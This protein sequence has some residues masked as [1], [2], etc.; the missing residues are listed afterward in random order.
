MNNGK[1]IIDIIESIDASLSGNNYFAAISSSL[2]L[3]EICASLEFENDFSKKRFLKWT[4]K[5]LIPLLNDKYKAYKYLNKD[6]LYYLRCSLFHQGSTDPSTQNKYYEKDFKK[7]YDI[8]PFIT[9][10][11]NLEVIVTDVENPPVREHSVNFESEVKL[12]TVF[13]EVRYL[14]RNITKA[15]ISWL[16]S[17]K[18]SEKFQKKNMNIFSVAKIAVNEFDDNKLLLCRQ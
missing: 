1:R 11:S 4:D 15:S 14:C 17:I 7:V 10:D 8:V 18:D 5:Y 16:D 2:I 6:N 13:V 12:P 3:I 9:H